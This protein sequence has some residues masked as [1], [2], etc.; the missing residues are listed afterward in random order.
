MF[1]IN[2]KNLKIAG[3]IWGIGLTVFVLGYLF[4][5]KPQNSKL[6][7]LTNKLQKINPESFEAKK[8]QLKEQID[9]VKVQLDGFAIESEDV[10]DLASIE[11]FN[12][13]K[14]NNLDAF[15]IKPWRDREVAAF[16][17]SKYVY[18]Q[19]IEVSFNATFSEFAKFLNKL[20]RNK[21]VIFVDSF[22]ITRAKGDNLK[23][24]VD[25]CLAV[26]VK[27]EAAAINAQS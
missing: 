4:I 17:R 25:M 6:D 16:K 12:L 1:S 2:R 22:S 23:H 26:L 21:S 19:F 5:I 8:K 15:L 7:E 13:A 24:K 9:S 18:G 27:K 14:E 10:Q 3:T 20:E 11:I